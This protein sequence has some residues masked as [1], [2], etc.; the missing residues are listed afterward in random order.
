VFSKAAC[1]D[2][3]AIAV[4][5]PGPRGTPI[6]GVFNWETPS[7]SWQTISLDNGAGLG[8]DPL[9]W[10]LPLRVLDALAKRA[11]AA[12]APTAAAG[13]LVARLNSGSSFEW[14]SATTPCWTLTPVMSTV[15]DDWLLALGQTGSSQRVTIRVYRW[16]AGGWIEVASFAHV[17]QSGDAASSMSVSTAS[18]A[19]TTFSL[20][21][22]GHAPPG[23]MATISDA[24]GSWHL[25]WARQPD[26]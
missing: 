10:D 13:D 16:S 11:G 3:W 1:A 5:N 23:P 25:G 20:P 8:K 2:G 7:E 6:V 15:S 9:S 18:R 17:F 19:T 26:L 24:G 14:L 12:V 4:S 21:G 22:Y